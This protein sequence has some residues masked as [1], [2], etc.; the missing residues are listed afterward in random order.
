MDETNPTP[1]GAM[2]GAAN[3]AGGHEPD[4][5]STQ[6]SADVTSADI[7]G[8]S[9]VLQQ[10][11]TPDMVAAGYQPG[12]ATQ[13]ITIGDEGKGPKVPMIIAAILVVIGLI[14]FG[15]GIA[16]GASLEDTFNKLST[17]DYTTSIGDSGELTHDDEDGMGEEGW[18]LLIPG[19]VKADENNNGIIDACE[20]VTFSVLDETGDDASDRTAR[21]SCSTDKEAS[22]TNLYEQYFDIE[23]HIIVARICYTVGDDIEEPEHECEEG[24]VLTVSNDAGINMS[25]VDLDAMYIESGFVEELLTKSGISV[26]SFGAGCCSACGGLIAL[27][28]GL[29]RLGGKEPAKQY[30]FQIQ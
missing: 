12:M 23:D 22:D 17:V 8:P 16:V 15:T 21:I 1:W 7:A 14:G 24:E 13:N 2:M 20:G 27:I 29:T 3:D 28:I 9:P 6:T 19:D 25:V 5:T 26:A 11:I 4:G 10:Q 18:Y 30:Q